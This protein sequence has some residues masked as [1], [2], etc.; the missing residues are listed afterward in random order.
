MRPVYPCG[1]CSQCGRMLHVGFIT[2]YSYHCIKD[3]HAVD[4]DDGCTFGDAGGNVTATPDIG[5]ML[6]ADYNRRGDGWM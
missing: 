6:P 1:E 2:R 5:V 4:A 3:N